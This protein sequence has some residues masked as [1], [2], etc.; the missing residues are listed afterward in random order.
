M[1]EQNSIA[2]SHLK[3]YLMILGARLMTDIKNAISG[4]GTWNPAQA[5]PD[6]RFLE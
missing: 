1:E 2:V 6:S 5:G 3:P 4:L